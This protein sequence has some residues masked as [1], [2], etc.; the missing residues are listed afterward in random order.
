MPQKKILFYVGY[1]SHIPHLSPIYQSLRKD[2]RYRAS[3]MRSTEYNNPTLHFLNFLT[4][5]AGLRGDVFYDPDV[6]FIAHCTHQP[7]RGQGGIIIN[8]N[9]DVGSKGTSFFDD[10]EFT[11][12]ENSVDYIFAPSD[13]LASRL[14]KFLTKPKIVTTGMPK[15]DRMFRGEFNREEILNKLKLSGKRVIIFAPTYNSDMSAIE[16][17]GNS[18]MKLANEETALI[19]K[20]HCKV[21]PKHEALFKNKPENVAI[22]SK[23]EPDITPYMSISDLMISDYS[24]AWMEFMALDKPMVLINNPEAVQKFDDQFDFVFR[25]AGIEAGNF[26]EVKEAVETSFKN[27]GEKSALRKKYSDMLFD[28]RGRSTEHCVEVLSEICGI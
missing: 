5:G 15:L 18:V 13:H 16:V 22:L 8:I 10:P 1:D 11:P 24:S 2:K 27:P 12:R 25:D 9:H 20:F 23:D 7:E 21:K 3:M 17:L 28:Y 4:A 19:V 14:R 6:T 26:E